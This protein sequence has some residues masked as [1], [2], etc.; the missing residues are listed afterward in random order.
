MKNLKIGI[1]GLGYVGLPLAIEFGKYFDVLGFDTNLERINELKL[2]KDITREISKSD[3]KK[4]KYLSF[5][6]D[7][8]NLADCNIFIV[9]VPTPVTKNN[10]PDLSFLQKACES[11]STILKKKDIVIFESTVYPGA[12]EDFC[13]PILEKKSGLIFNLDFFC[14]Y[15]PERI[16]PGDKINTLTNVPK[17]TSGSNSTVSKKI[18]GLYKKIIT[19]GTYNVKSIKIAEAAKVIEN[20]QRDL[21]IAFI[22]ELSVLFDKLNLDTV[23]V[24]KAAASKW[25]FIDFKPGMVGGHC[26]C[27]DPYY[28]TFIAE[29]VGYHPEIILAGRRLNDNMAKYASKNFVKLM[30]KNK[31]DVSRATVG[32]MGITF[33]E[34]CPD[35]RNSKI[36]DIV[37]ELKSWNIKF[38]ILDDW[39]SSKELELKHKLK[40]SDKN[41]FKNLDSIIVAVGHKEFRA[42]KPQELLKMCK[43]NISPVLADL[44]SLYNREACEKI[45]FSVFR[46]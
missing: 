18:D 30:I 2:K 20:T 42:L 44:K 11:I 7:L 12:T 36:F 1:L 45:G 29:S 40:T 23:E 17:I 16:N 3:F 8:N 27:V 28:L 35:I 6:K 14:G 9:T 43:K 31:I 39:A 33:K 41:D 21:N 22:N 26:I 38:K 4:A 5:E 19:A 13:I 37:D 32:I 15:S 34:N 24:L 10:Q 46:L 25:N